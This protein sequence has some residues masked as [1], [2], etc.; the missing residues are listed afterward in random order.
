MMVGKDCMHEC[1]CLQRPEEDVRFPG[2]GVEGDCDLLDLVLLL[3][4]IR[5]LSHLFSSL[6]FV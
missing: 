2:A 5:A 3:N 6:D 4:P 1:R